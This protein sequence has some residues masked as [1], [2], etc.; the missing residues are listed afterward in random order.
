MS[1]IIKNDS[2]IR[3]IATDSNKHKRA[4]EFV[5]ELRKKG[6]T[7]IDVNGL[8]PM[9]V[10]WCHRENCVNIVATKSLN[11]KLKNEL[12]ELKN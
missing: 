4:S 7:C 3:D 5:D 12:N 11:K 8:Y 1:Q 9:E 10:C 6:H 2:I